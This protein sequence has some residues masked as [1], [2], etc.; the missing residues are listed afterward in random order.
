MHV[1]LKTGFKKSSTHLAFLKKQT[2]VFK[3]SP[4][5]WVFLKNKIVILKKPNPLGLK[6]RFFKTRTKPGLF[7]KSHL[8]GFW[9]HFIEF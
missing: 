9:G 4:T 7:K 1:R 6:K 2:R 8:S 3:K 5:H